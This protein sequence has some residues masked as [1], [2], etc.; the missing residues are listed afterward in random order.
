MWINTPEDIEPYLGFVYII[1]NHSKLNS[2]GIPKFY[3]GQKKFWFK[4]TLPP[5]KGKTRKRKKLVESDW[6]EYTGSSELLNADIKNGDSIT[7][8]ILYLCETKWSMN[9]CEMIEQV[10]RQVLLEDDLSYNGI[11][12]VRIGRCTIK[13][14]EKYKKITEDLF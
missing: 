4:K 7:K 9:Y 6:K 1:Q 5:L 8:T 10:K 13:N 11:I 3:I 2:D 14:R 12:N